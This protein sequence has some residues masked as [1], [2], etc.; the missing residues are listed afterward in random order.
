MLEPIVERAYRRYL[1]TD[2]TSGLGYA[3]MRKLFGSAR[4]Q[5]FDALADR[6]T[7]ERPRLDLGAASGVLA[8]EVADAAAALRRD[9][10]VLLRS[11]LP[12][13]ECAALEAV[14]VAADCD[15]VARFTPGPDRARFDAGAPEAVRYDVPEAV[16]LQD[17]MVQTLLGDESVLAVAQEYLGGAPVHDLVAMWWTAPS[18]AESSAAAQQ[19]HFDLDRLRFVKLF[20][21]LTDVG[22]ANG[23]HHY[24]KGS[25]RDLPRQLRA[26][27]RFTDAEVLGHYGAD[28]L[29]EITGPRGSMFLADTRGLHKGLN[30]VEGHRL[31][32]QLECST[33]LF[34]KPL[35]RPSV[36]V[37]APA[38]RAAIA[39]HPGAYRRLLAEDPRR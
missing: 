1:G 17:E 16:L 27:R 23:P 8:G 19:F 15:V 39:S 4:P 33:S 12:E 22:P 38:L 31:V 14:A 18:T 7:R 25:H 30:V 29:V 34:G 3:A 2:R 5:A 9:G 32:F 37:A 36:P 26:D 28:A 21:Y 13:A 10:V 11:R 6:S 35:D 24:V 20:V